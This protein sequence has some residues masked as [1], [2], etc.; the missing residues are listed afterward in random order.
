MV[1]KNRNIVRHNM[2]TSSRMPP[3]SSWLV[4]TA[5]FRF[6]L[7]EVSSTIKEVKAGYKVNGPFPREAQ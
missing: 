7:E 3:C 6:L 2:H 4:K 1:F 5:F